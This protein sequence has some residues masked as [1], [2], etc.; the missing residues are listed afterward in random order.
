MNIT[1]DMVKEFVRDYI[2]TLKA[3]NKSLEEYRDVYEI[4]TI[5]NIDVETVNDYIIIGWVYCGMFRRKYYQPTSYYDIY[6]N[7]YRVE[8]LNY[9]K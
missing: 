8:G 9:E 3:M 2:G 7:K 5:M 6:R 4:S 1:E